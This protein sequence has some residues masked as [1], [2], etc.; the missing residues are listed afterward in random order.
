MAGAVI[1][2]GEA[3]GTTAAGAVAP[4]PG[5]VGPLLSV[6][7]TDT[8]ITRYRTRVRTLRRRGT[9]KMSAALGHSTP[10]LVRS[11]SAG[12]TWHDLK[13]AGRLCRI[14]HPGRAA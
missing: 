11:F 3:I 2:S 1:T 4:S 14:R 7:C 8:P 6:A 9:L 5:W 12:V 13:E 10:A